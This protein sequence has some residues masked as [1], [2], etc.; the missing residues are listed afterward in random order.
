MWLGKASEELTVAEAKILLSDFGESFC[1]QEEDKFES[2]TPSVNRAPEARF[3]AGVKPLSFPSDI[4]SLAC[5]IWDIVGQSPLFEGFLSREDDITREHVDA[6]GILP[7]EWWNKWTARRSKF[8]EDGTPLDGRSFRSWDDRFEYC[9][10][11]AR[12]VERMPEF[13]P[14][15]RDALFAMSRSMLSFR[16]E[17]RPS[18]KDVLTS[19]LM[20]K[21][22]LLECEKT[23][24]S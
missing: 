10:Q 1:V 8:N 18:A 14:A 11:K 5:T 24:K 23:W 2:H 15:E 6:L 17:S 9:V 22:A 20:V 19:E 12:R 7:Q 4:W 16:P 21:W 13:E 3:Q